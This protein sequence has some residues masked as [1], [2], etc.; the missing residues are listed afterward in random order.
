MKQYLEVIK[1]R[2]FHFVIPGVL[3]FLFVVILT[4]VL[5]PIYKAASTILIEAQEIPQDLV[6]TTVTGYVEERLQSIAK[7]VLSRANLEDV[8]QC[9]IIAPRPQLPLRRRFH[10]AYMYADKLTDLLHVAIDLVTGR[11]QIRGAE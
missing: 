1:R 8:I 7:I 11:Q 6:R 10:Q 9:A 2:K 4:F 3:V 5:P